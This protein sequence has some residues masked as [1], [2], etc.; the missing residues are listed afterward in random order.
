MFTLET[1]RRLSR[2][3]HERLDSPIEAGV[4]ARTMAPLQLVVGHRVPLAWAVVNGAPG[5]V[6][7]HPILGLVWP[8]IR[9][10]RPRPLLCVRRGHFLSAGS[11]LN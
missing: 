3:S 5:L 11:V 2:V 1:R 6:L 10:V 8:F 7:L 4:A 9:R